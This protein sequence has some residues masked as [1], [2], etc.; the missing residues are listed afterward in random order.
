MY[1]YVRKNR[2]TQLY[3]LINRFSIK[4]HGK[5]VRRYITKVIPL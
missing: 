3:L 1:F 5:D 2:Y 4:N